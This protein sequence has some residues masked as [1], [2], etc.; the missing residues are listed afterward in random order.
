MAGGHAVLRRHLPRAAAGAGA[1]SRRAVRTVFAVHAALQ[2]LVDRQHALGL[3]PVAL[4]DD[5]QDGHLSQRC[6]HG[7]RADALRQRFLAQPL[8]PLPEGRL[9]LPGLLPRQDHGRQHHRHDRHRRPARTP[10]R[11]TPG[12]IMPHEGGLPRRSWSGDDPAKA[13]ILPRIMTSHQRNS[14]MSALRPMLASPALVLA[15]LL[16][17]APGSLATAPVRAQAGGAVRLDPALLSELRFRSVGPHRG[18]RVTAVAGH[19]RQP[20]TFYM[21][22]TGGGVWKT[23]DSGATWLNV[24][25]GFFATGS[26]GAIDVAESNPDIVYVGTGSAAIRSNVIQGR[27]VYKSSRRREDVGLRRAARGRPDR[28]AE[29]PPDEPGRRL[30]RR[31]RPAVRPQPGARRLQDDRRR[32]D[33]GRRCS[34]STTAP[35][36]SRWR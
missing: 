7:S 33:A 5:R 13:G 12:H 2:V 23:T 20:A 10:H 26:I 19:R 29:G 27:G 30:R 17:L 28:R 14:L 3:R 4:D 18:G 21:G 11:R 34:S 8:Q 25:D 36:P 24:S 32:Q 1:T 15:A 16:V 35:A 9:L 31:A 22:A 6:L